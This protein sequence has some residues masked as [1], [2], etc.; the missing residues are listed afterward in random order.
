MSLLIEKVDSVFVSSY[1][2]EM[3]DP[4]DPRRADYPAT[5]R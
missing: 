2:I 1:D 5:K 3:I 4:F